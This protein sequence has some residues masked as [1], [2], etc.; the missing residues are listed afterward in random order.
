MHCDL[1]SWCLITASP[2][3]NF[4]QSFI[5]EKYQQAQKD[6]AELTFPYKSIN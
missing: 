4:A 5:V 1:I 6:L 2:P 3:G